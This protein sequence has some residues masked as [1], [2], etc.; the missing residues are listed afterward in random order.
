MIVTWMGHLYPPVGAAG[1]EWT[2]HEFLL[3][4]K[5]RGHDVSF[6]LLDSKA[7]YELEG[8]PV[9]RQPPPRSHVAIG[10]LGNAHRL[11][12]YASR[13]SAAVG[14]MAHA[15]N[16]WAWYR[17]PVAWPI[18]NSETTRLSCRD[19]H[20]MRPH[21]P[22]WRYGRDRNAG[23][24]AITLVNVSKGKGAATFGALAALMPERSFLGVRGAYDGQEWKTGRHGN[25]T[26]WDNQPNMDRVLDAT[27]VLLVPSQTESWGRVAAEAAHH[28]IPT[29]AAP[30]DGLREAL[31]TQT[32]F[33]DPA[34][35][36][37]WA[38]E[39]GKLLG[40]PS[41]YRERASDA[42][43]RAAHLEVVTK[44][45]QE[46]LINRLEETYGKAR[47]DS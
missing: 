21:T 3:A 20:L 28:G 44:G 17:G 9:V 43:Q 32:V 46:R 12:S 18:A 16:Q 47:A 11:A 19:A 41:Y 27:K 38:D 14:W 23:G 10:H 22:A 39:I 7:D 6:W 30:C 13:A 34:D 5:R 31:G 35:T 8:I 29:I 42:R 2:A 24:T 26:I 25:I 33:I 15:P 40:D 45:D 37:A 4:L 1:A 36:Y